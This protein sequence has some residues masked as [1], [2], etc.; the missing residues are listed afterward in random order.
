MLAAVRPEVLAELIFCWSTKPV[1]GWALEQ[2]RREAGR[3][4]LKLPSY[5]Q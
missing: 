5:T 1:I 4:C 3:P 2:A